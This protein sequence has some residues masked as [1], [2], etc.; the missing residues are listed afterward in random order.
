MILAT[1]RG[2]IVASSD[3]SRLGQVH[4]G[5]ARILRGEADEVVVSREEEEASGAVMR[6]GINRAV[7]ID[8]TRVASVGC[9]GDPVTVRPL[10]QVALKWMESE[11]RVTREEAVFRAHMTQTA[12][13]VSELLGAIQTIAQQTK[14]LAV[15]ATIEAAR[16]GEAGL[17]FAVVATE[18]RALSDRT[19]RAVAS[20]TAKL[21]GL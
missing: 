12:T 21:E 9:A 5:A 10:I 6:M 16:A 11:L 4:D 8:G 13:E 19:E 17:G 20:I 7:D 3:W 14:L 1:G 15:N 2:E 18:V